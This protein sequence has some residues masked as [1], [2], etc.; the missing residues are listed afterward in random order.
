M[1]KV[2]I[3]IFLAYLRL[4]ARIQLAKIR[5]QIV[6]LTGSMGKTSLC[7]AMATVLATRY[8]VKKSVKANSET[9]I[10][11]DLLGLHPQEYNLSEWLK[12]FFLIPIKLLTN[13]QKYDIYVAELGV[14]DPYPPK[15][16]EYLLRF[17]KPDV[18]VFL[19]VASVHTEQFAKLIHPNKVFNSNKEREDFLLNAIAQE[20]GKIITELK[21][22]KVAIV[23]RDDR[24]VWQVAPRIKA[25]LRAFGKEA[26]QPG[27]IKIGEIK[28]FFKGKKII[29]PNEVATRFTFNYQTKKC[30]V[31]LPLLV[32]D[33]YSSTL[34]A[35][36]SVGLEFG[37]SIDE[38]GG[39]LAKSFKLPASRMGL[40][41]GIN[42]S[43]LIDS[44][45]NASRIATIGALELLAKVPAKPKVV[46]L[47]DMRELGEIAREEHGAVAKEILKVA[48]EVILVGPLTQE[49][50]FPM[51]SPK[52]PTQWFVNSWQATEY[53]KLHLKSGS[54]VLIKGSQN[55]IFTEI[56]VEK[57]LKNPEDAKKLCRRGAF[58]DRQRQKLKINLS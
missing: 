16:M 51:V 48:D 39:A 34:A 5:P 23:N 28:H 22:D 50:V 12:L 18:G 56:V 29:H 17:I 43:L 19:N 52:L 6:A 8:Q 53:L 27:Q 1:K 58:W 4:A 55:T 54:V 33:Y 41:S 24:W 46:V 31:E 37:I 11:L 36:L 14:D 42:N 35:A 7:N 21:P 2:I 32:P 3:S 25:K 10:P 45:Y 38:S 13:W 44:S 26:D 47:G 57:L 15:N 40:F 49:Y 9:G 30:L 20:K